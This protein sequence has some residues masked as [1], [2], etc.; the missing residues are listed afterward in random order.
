MR[1]IGCNLSLRIQAGKWSRCN[2][3]IVGRFADMDCEISRPRNLS[4]FP[5]QGL[6]RFRCI[7][8][9][10]W[11]LQRW[12]WV[13]NM[14][15]KGRQRRCKI[16]SG[17]YRDGLSERNFTKSRVDCLLPRL[18]APGWLAIRGRRFFG[19]WHFNSILDAWALVTFVQHEAIDYLNHHI[20]RWCHGWGY[21]CFCGAAWWRDSAGRKYPGMLTKNWGLII[22]GLEIVSF[23][24]LVFSLGHEFWDVIVHEQLPTHTRNVGMMSTSPLPKK[25]ETQLPHLAWMEGSWFQCHSL[26][27]NESW[28][29]TLLTASLHVLICSASST[30]SYMILTRC[31]VRVWHTVAVL[32][33]G[34]NWTHHEELHQGLRH[35]PYVHSFSLV[36]LDAILRWGSMLFSAIFSPFVSRCITL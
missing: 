7:F 14:R 34:W 22:I 21:C 24:L 18:T 31:R 11:W 9:D 25:L 4:M 33:Y 29:D 20:S 16:P 15:C 8:V 5:S 12:P 35:V 17:F 26:K 36:C 28:I 3:G 23:M 30:R 32:L 19:G 13:S 27:S 6:W 10:A 2:R 1:F